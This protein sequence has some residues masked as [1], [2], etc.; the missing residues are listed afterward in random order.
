MWPSPEAAS[1]AAEITVPEVPGLPLGTVVPLI[2]LVS[3]LL[4]AGF[5]ASAV[6]SL[7]RGRPAVDARLLVARGAVLGLSL[8]SAATLLKTLELRT[9]RQFL[10][11]A[12]ILTLRTVLKRTFAREVREAGLSARHEFGTGSAAGLRG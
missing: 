11:L 7:V 2:E 5:V 12:A 6:V 10:M 9:L 4:V 3:G 1:A 8:K